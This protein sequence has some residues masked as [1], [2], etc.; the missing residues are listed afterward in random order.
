MNETVR[1]AFDASIGELERAV[2][3]PTGDLG[4]GRDLSCTTEIHPGL[5]EV[6]PMSP[7]GIGEAAIRRLT[8]PRGGLPDD[9][10]Y[11]LDLRSFANRGVPYA[12]L[13]DL[14]GMIRNELA[15]D[16]RIADL[17]VTVT[18]SRSTDLA[19][20]IRIVPEHPTL[21]PF[22]LVFVVGADGAVTVEALA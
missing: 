19:V 1:A 15:K 13:R 5:A 18:L 8:T 2:L 21:A 9:A 20:S 16:D 7:V 11:G 10:D 12:E 22:A 17:T 6:D 14:Q 4:Y 3:P